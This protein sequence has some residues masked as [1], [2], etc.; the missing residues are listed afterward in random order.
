M[1]PGSHVFS[2]AAYSPNWSPLIAAG[3][4]GAFGFGGGGTTFFRPQSGHSIFSP[5]C[6][7]IALIRVSHN[8]Q[9][10]EIHCGASGSSENSAAGA[11]SAAAASA[12]IASAG[13]GV[14]GG[15]AGLG[16]CPPIA[17]T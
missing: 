3:I 4:T 10:N 14:A 16:A 13:F 9:W 8:E 15:P 5:T 11:I 7:G 2:S 12:A 17:N 1:N 6:E